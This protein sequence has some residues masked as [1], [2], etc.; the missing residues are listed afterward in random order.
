[1][2]AD[3]PRTIKLDVN[4][5]FDISTGNLQILTGAESIAQ[6]V[7][8]TLQFFKGEWF[9]NLDAGLPYFQS[10]LVKNPDANQLQAIFRDAILAVPGVSALPSLTL[11]FDRTTRALSVR[12]RV[13]TDFGELDVE[14]VL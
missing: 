2:A 14:E 6:A 12:C 9:L 8:I 11:T 4:G 10:I 5:D 7:R 13:S 1:M 3:T